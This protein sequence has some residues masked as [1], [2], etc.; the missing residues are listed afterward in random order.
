MTYRMF[1]RS[2]TRL[3]RIVPTKTTMLDDARLIGIEINFRSLK[4][5]WTVK[6]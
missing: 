1:S 6:F 3:V 2:I 4:E 5:P